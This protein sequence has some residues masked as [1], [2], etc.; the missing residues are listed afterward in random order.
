MS[1]TTTASQ[2]KLSEITKLVHNL[3]SRVQVNAATPPGF[4][5]LTDQRNVID[6]DDDDAPWCFGHPSLFQRRLWVLKA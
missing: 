1:L 2:R 6:N 4:S 5:L 3:Q